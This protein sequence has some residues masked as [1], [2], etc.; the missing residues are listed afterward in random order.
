MQ[1]FQMHLEVEM[2]F[3]GVGASV[4]LTDYLTLGHLVALGYLGAEKGT[5]PGSE[6]LVMLDYRQGAVGRH[7]AGKHHR[8]GRR[9]DVDSAV[10]TG[11]VEGEVLRGAES[12][13]VGVAFHG[14]DHAQLGGVG[15]LDEVRQTRCDV[16]QNPDYY[17]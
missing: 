10:E 3:R 17:Q 7:L 12:Q 5:V 15:L 8:A 11:G 13:K 4:N 2:I 16:G 9:G 14:P 1:V 6:P